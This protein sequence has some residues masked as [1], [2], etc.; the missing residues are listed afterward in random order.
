MVAGTA[1]DSLAVVAKPTY[2]F[3]GDGRPPAQIFDEGFKASGTNTDVL[4]HATTNTNSG[5]ISTSSTPNVAR[6]FADMQ[7]DGYVYT[8]RKPPQ[9]LDVNATLGAKSPYPQEFE[10]VVPGAIRPQ[11]ILG[12]RQV[13]PDGKF[14]GP[15]VKNTGF[16]P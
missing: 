16:Q 1:G 10:I 8:V 7:V 6:E 14:V 9:A 3:R 13:G 15:F 2:V 11:D 12:A 4:N 5:L